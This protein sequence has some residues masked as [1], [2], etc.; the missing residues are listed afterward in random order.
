M[1]HAMTLSGERAGRGHRVVV[2]APEVPQ[3]I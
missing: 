3:G 2:K 1:Q